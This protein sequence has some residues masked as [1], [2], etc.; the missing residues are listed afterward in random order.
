[1][2]RRKKP[3][4]DLFDAIPRSVEAARKVARAI[5]ASMGAER[6]RSIAAAE[7]IGALRAA[8][9]YLSKRK[10]KRKPAKRKPPPTTV[11]LTAR[12]IAEIPRQRALAAAELVR[13]RE[14]VTRDAIDAGATLGTM[15]QMTQAWGI[16][17]DRWVT[18]DEDWPEYDDGDVSMHDVYEIW[19]GYAD[20]VA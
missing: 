16:T 18:G 8:D 17:P 15:V 7:R 14:R 20:A 11:P 10:R 12:E 1:M 6:Y 3:R 19:F 2:A 4:T 9:E 13:F 5:G